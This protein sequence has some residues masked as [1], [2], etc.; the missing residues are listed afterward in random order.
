MARIERILRVCDLHDG[1]TEGRRAIFVVASR[2]YQIDACD[3]HAA[4]L[5]RA[6]TL[7]ERA[8]AASL[9]TAVKRAGTRYRPRLTIR[10]TSRGSV[11]P[12]G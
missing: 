9:A 7:I 10:A 6:V 12:G 8:R 1:D 11:T 2:I 3:Q 5:R 4:E